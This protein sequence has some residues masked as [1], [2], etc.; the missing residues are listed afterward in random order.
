MLAFMNLDHQQVRSRKQ[1]DD[2]SMAYGK[3]HILSRTDDLR[4]A[5]P[6]L[7]PLDGKTLLD[8]ACGHGH[9]AVFFAGIGARVTAADLSPRMLERTGELA[10]EAGVDLD[11][12]EHEAESLPYEDGSY[13]YVTCRIA[14]H[15]FSCPASFV[16]E[17]AR[18]LRPGGRFLLIDGTVEDG[19]PEAEAWAHEV[20]ILRDPSHNRFVSPEKWI[21][22]TGH[23]GLKTVFSEVTFFQQPDIQWYFDCAKTPPENRQRVLELMD[24]A[25]PEARTLFR[26][27]GEGECWTWWWQRLILVARK[28]RA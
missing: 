19:H 22:L 20:E 7:K 4:T 17:V 18:V 16:M 1:F 21:H 2:R 3:S 10:K 15:H 11:L 27:E 25:P 14:A 23:V 5:L 24:N 13:D 28:H 9:G 12:R 6:H 26:I 8:I